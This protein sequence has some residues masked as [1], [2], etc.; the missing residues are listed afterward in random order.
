MQSHDNLG[1]LRFDKVLLSSVW[2]YGLTVK[3]LQTPKLLALQD[4]YK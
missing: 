4:C 3:V 2:F 1:V